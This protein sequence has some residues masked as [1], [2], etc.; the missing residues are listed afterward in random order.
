MSG[1]R[2]SRFFAALSLVLATLA[3][4][5]TAQSRG[6]VEQERREFAE[7]LRT[8]ALSPRRA[9]GVFPLGGGLRL[10]SA[11]AD[12][13]LAGVADARLSERGGRIELL[14]GEKNRPVARGRPIALGAWQLLLS[15]PPGRTAVTVFAATLKAGKQPAW[16]AYDSALVLPVTLTP[17]PAPGTLRVLAPEGVEVEASEAGTVRFTLDGKPQSLRVRR[18]PGASDEEAELE[19]YFRDATNGK[20][21][22]PAG[23]FVS[24]IP[25]TAGGGRYLLDLNRARN[26]FCAYN[27]AYPCPAPW[28]GNALIVAMPAGERYQGG[29]LDLP[30][31]G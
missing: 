25:L 22:Y 10:G 17:A 6:T 5:L 30:P 28:R 15:G 27:T 8:A 11:T 12:I 4:S 21:T 14:A 9:V 13:P 24:L 20:T 29:G 2:W 3:A 16:F 18:M 31:K 7:W 26:P 1:K 19:I 23:R